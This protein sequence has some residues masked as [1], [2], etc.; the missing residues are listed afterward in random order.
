MLR[1][2]IVHRLDRGTSG[3]IVV[4]KHDDA[5]RAL[6]AQF[7]AHTIERVYQAL[8]RGDS[9]ARDAAASTPRSRAIRA[10]ASA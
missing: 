9:V 3:V 5:H 7:H 8:V 6:A 2:G 1:P 10:T 4:A